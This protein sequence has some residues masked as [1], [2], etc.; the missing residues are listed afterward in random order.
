MTE[1]AF[2]NPLQ[3]CATQRP[4]TAVAPH[5][6]QSDDCAPVVG[7]RGV[8]SVA[9]EFSHVYRAPVVFVPRRR[10]TPP[11]AGLVSSWP[12]SSVVLVGAYGD[13]DV[14]NAATM[15]DYAL[16]HARGGCGL[17]LDLRG[18][19]FFGTEGFS[20]LH[21]VAVGCARIGTAWSVVPGAAVWRLVRICDRLGSLPTVD[22]VDAA[23][24]RVQDD[25]TVYRGSSRADGSHG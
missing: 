23:L 6:E 1:V 22:T 2:V 4:R 15:T 24:A 25:I 10:C 14:T 20:A 18:L 9:T 8:G 11:M 7:V 13:I 12:T 5:S 19:N 21:R 3:A 16:V 17:I